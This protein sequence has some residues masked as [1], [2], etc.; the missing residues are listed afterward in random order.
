MKKFI[1]IAV[2]VLLIAIPILAPLMWVLGE[3]SY[4]IIGAIIGALW[5]LYL[6]SSFGTVKPKEVGMLTYFDKPLKDLEKGLYFAPLWVYDVDIE[7]GT[8]FQDELPADPQNIYRG[9]SNPPTGMFP[10]IR[11]KFGQPDPTDKTH[12]GDPYNVAMV[13]EIP[14]VVE[15]WVESLMKFRQKFGSIENARKIFADKAA[16]VFGDKFATMTPAKATAHLGTVSSE[17]ENKLRIDVAD[18]GI[19]IRDAYAKP[20]VFSHELN[21]S[22]VG[23]SIADQNAIAVEKTAVG[24]ANAHVTTQTAEINMAR[25][26][27]LSLGLLEPI[28]QGKKIVGYKQVAEINSVTWAEALKNSKLQFLSLDPKG[29]EGV[30][31]AILSTK[32]S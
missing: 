1:E 23:V 3:L 24:T 9:D 15:W 4:Q 11:V 17:L 12:E 14:I 10:P 28:M 27:L 32:T 20:I 26:R 31:A 25:T 29:L 2:Y 13:A 7:V 18:A 16:Q 8:V 5:L 30:M 6:G 22:V 19:G 21:T